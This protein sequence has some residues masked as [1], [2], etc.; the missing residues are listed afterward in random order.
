MVTQRWDHIGCFSSSELSIP[1]LWSIQFAQTKRLNF[2]LFKDHH[3]S[4]RLF[5]QPLRL[6]HPPPPGS[7][8]S[9]I[10]MIIGSISVE[11]HRQQGTFFLSSPQCCTRRPCSLQRF[12]VKTDVDSS[13]ARLRVIGVGVNLESSA[14]V[15]ACASQAESLDRLNTTSWFMNA[16]LE[17]LQRTLTPDE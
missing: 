14:S 1:D 5:I 16:S 13:T 9:Q 10:I 15:K 17:N 12:L 7:F 2:K 8:K 6:L 11:A 4:S 3:T